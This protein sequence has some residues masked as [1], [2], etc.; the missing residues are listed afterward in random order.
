VTEVW[1]DV[2][3]Y[4]GF[5]QASTLGRI[6]SLG[7]VFIRSDGK[8]M[9]LR[10][11][12]LKPS[13]APNGYKMCVLCRDAKWYAT[14]HSVV[15]LTFHGERPPEMEVCHNDGVKINCMPSNLRYGTKVSNAA[16]KILHGT[17]QRGTKNI[18]C[19][20]T[21][22]QVIE[23]RAR[24]AAGGVSLKTLASSYGV[25]LSGIHYAITAHNWSWLSA[26]ETA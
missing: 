26:K 3:G 16:D 14:V 6:K 12:I 1:K 10:E 7:R 22:E 17:I 13:I 18:R 4:E 15:A 20:L 11:R 21:E 2:P 25:S 24:Y 8:R 5:Y 23:A 9:T 19:K